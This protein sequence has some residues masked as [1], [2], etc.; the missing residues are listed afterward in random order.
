LLDVLLSEQNM[1]SSRAMGT[2]E[3]EAFR[4]VVVVPTYNNAQ[5]LEEVLKRIECVGIPVIVV[6]DGSTDGTSEI[7]LKWS[8]SQ[9]AVPR[10]LIT[11]PV[12]R[13]KAAAL[14]SGFEEALQRGCSHA[15]S[16]DSDGQLA[17]EEI[18]RLLDAAEQSP[19]AMVLGT[20][21]ENAPGYPAKSRVGRRISNLMVKL[22]SGAKVSDSQC[23]MRVY[24]LEL[25]RFINCRTERYAFE[26]AIL[27]RAAWAGCSFVEVP[28]TCRYDQGVRI[29]HLRPWVDTWRGIAM[30]FPLTVRALLPWP[31]RKWERAP[32]RDR[33]TARSIGKHFIQSLN[34]AAAFRELRRDPAA[35]PALALALGLGVLIANLPLYGVQTVTA[36]YLARRLHLNPLALVL[37]TQ[38]SMPPIGPL[39]IAAAIAVGHFILHGSMPAM[40]N[41]DVR[42]LGWGRV[43]GPALLDWIVGGVVVGMILGTAT[44]FVSWRLFRRVSS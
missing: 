29:S 23:G 5:T 17:P 44:F 26:T 9:G 11:H 24:P 10:W 12:N 20:R 16:I 42:H 1:P 32:K 3:R 18:P 39:L 6:N 41:L 21:D 4:P 19:L 38:A 27:T 40:A 33:S 28:V 31:H 15:V 37:G 34:P 22:E 7:L 2:S 14:R 43:I 25:M 13:G 8:E 36:I 30:H 35:G